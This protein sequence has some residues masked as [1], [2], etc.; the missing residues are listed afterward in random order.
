[1][2]F[3]SIFV[4]SGVIRVWML[5]ARLLIQLSRAA[6][7]GNV[8]W[9]TLPYREAALTRGFAASSASSTS[10]TSM[11]VSGMVATCSASAFSKPARLSVLPLLLFL[12][13]FLALPPLVGRPAPPPGGEV[14]GGPPFSPGRFFWGAP[15][16]TPGRC[17]G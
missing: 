7:L 13:P 1:M 3:A 5:L 10:S 11:V 6:P 15:S 9:I 14:A 4:A 8:L 16:T 17:W 2:K 12:P